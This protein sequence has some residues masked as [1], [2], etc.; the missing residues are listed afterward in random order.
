[1]ECKKFENF[2]MQHFEKTIK[3]K[4]A[5]TLAQHILTCSPCRQMYL[6]M[7]EAMETEETHA[8]AGFEAAVMTSVRKHVAET[9][10][11]EI[12]WSIK[13]VWAV[14]AILIAIASFV[15]FNPAALESTAILQQVGNFFAIFAT[16]VDAAFSQGVQLF[17]NT[18][19]SEVAG[20]SAMSLLFIFMICAVLAVLYQDE[21]QGG[22]VRA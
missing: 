18:D 16:A 13:C 14:S 5:K 12:C 6:M 21:K 8:P 15:A 7:D 1:M 20:L 4:N 2:I 10:P 9:R 22:A 11:Q 19:I 3:P 17:M